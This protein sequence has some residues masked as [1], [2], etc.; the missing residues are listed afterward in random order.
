[1]RTLILLGAALIAGGTMA[2]PAAAATAT[3]S[4]AAKP[5]PAD[6]CDAKYYSYLVG[7]DMAETATINGDYRVLPGSVAPPA[8]RAKRLTF[9]YDKKSNRIV[10]VACG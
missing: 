3:T 7:R 1:M 2:G 5:K 9:L 10:D 8:T 4:P 6:T